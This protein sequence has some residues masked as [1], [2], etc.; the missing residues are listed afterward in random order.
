MAIQFVE[1][2]KDYVPSID[3]IAVTQLLLRYVPQEFQ[4]GLESITLTNTDAL[5]RQRRRRRA[6]GGSRVAQD[7]GLYYEP[8]NGRLARIEIFLDKTLQGYP[9]LLLKVPFIKHFAVSDVLYHEIGHHMQF[10]QGKN[11][12]RQQE[13]L[14][15]QYERKL[16]DLFLRKHYWYGWPLVTALRWLWRIFSGPSHTFRR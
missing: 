5:S 6:I 9:H 2:Y 4:R 11:A 8:W 16:Y 1:V 12:G 10:L 3:A 13:A 15:E 14:A 7:R